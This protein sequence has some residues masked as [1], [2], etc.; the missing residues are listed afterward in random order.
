MYLLLSLIK[1]DKTVF[2]IQPKQ[3]SLPVLHQILTDSL[4]LA[5]YPNPAKKPNNQTNIL[6]LGER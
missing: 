5:L 6:G 1:V 3:S 4:P 2:R